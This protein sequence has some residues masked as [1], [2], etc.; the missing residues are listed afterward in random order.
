MSAHT[1]Y[2]S[3]FANVERDFGPASAHTLTGI[4]GFSA[5]GPVSMCRLGAE[6]V[7]VTRELSVSPDQKL[8][9]QGLR[10]ELLSR[11]PLSKSDTQDLLTNIGALSFDATLGNRHTVDVSAI[12]SSPDM[13]K[14][15]LRLYTSCE[16]G[17]AGYGIYE[18]CNADPAELLRVVG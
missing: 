5:G 13:K 4:I 9:A 14:I 3:L 1:H 7:Y 6:H 8:S 11:L 17:G 2:A 18:I 15:P 10:F 12:S 16:I